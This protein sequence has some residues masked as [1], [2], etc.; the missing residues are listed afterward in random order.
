MV[1]PRNKSVRAAYT[2]PMMVGFD[3]PTS[4]ALRYRAVDAASLVHV[5]HG[6]LYASEDSSR[7][8]GSRKRYAH[9]AS[10]RENSRTW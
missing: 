5:S 7:S 4:M 8:D 3:G 10:E 6:A 1:K 9:W 2:F